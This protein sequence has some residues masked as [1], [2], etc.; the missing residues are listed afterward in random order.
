MIEICRIVQQPE[1]NP[2]NDMTNFIIQIS[3][4]DFSKT[5]KE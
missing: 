2:L 4:K 1:A 5:A 3:Y